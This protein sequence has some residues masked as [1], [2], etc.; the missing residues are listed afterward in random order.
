[1]LRSKPLQAIRPG[2][3]RRRT[4]K[5]AALALALAM[6]LIVGLRQSASAQD[7]YHYFDRVDYRDGSL[8][9][10]RDFGAEDGSLVAR[11]DLA[12]GKPF[13]PYPRGKYAHE[14]R[15][16]RNEFGD[17]YAYEEAYA[18]AYQQAY[19]HTFRRY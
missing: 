8:R 3:I 18:R 17:K 1:M 4:V 13:Q 5:M 6:I 16:Y 10:A 2:I 19:E 11:Q 14:D 9:V 12:K 7:G 15:G